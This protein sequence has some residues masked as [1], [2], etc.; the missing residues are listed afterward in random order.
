MHQPWEPSKGYRDRPAIGKIDRQSIFGDADALGRGCPKFNRRSTHGIRPIISLRLAALCKELKVAIARETCGAQVVS[1]NEDGHGSVFWDHDWT[2]DASLGVDNMAAFFTRLAEPIA[3]KDAAE[4]AVV[5]RA[6]FWHAPTAAARR[7]ADGLR[8]RVL[9]KHRSRGEHSRT[10]GGADPKCPSFR[11]PP[12]KSRTA[13]M[14]LSRAFVSVGA[15]EERSSSGLRATYCS[16][17][18]KI[19]VVKWRSINESNQLV[20]ATYLKTSRSLPKMPFFLPPFLL[21]G[22]GGGRRL[23]GSPT[24]RFS[25]GAAPRPGTIAEPSSSG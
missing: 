21:G 6:K 8:F 12:K 3:F 4:Q 20:V 16:P 9:A 2:N 18:L 14:R 19:S 7:R 5:N 25:P 22:G 1:Y 23:P 11:P 24:P 10:P 13:S 17:S 15:Q